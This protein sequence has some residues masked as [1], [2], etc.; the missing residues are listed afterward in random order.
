MSRDCCVALSRGVMGL[1]AVCD[2]FFLLIILTYYL[3]NPI[4]IR[5]WA[6]NAAPVAYIYILI[7]WSKIPLEKLTALI[8]SVAMLLLIS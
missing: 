6:S 3:H 4:T 1:S 2:C 5:E 8:S 7:D